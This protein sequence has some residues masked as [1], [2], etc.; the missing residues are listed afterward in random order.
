MHS[1]ENRILM[2]N[3]VYKP[4]KYENEA[5]KFAIYLTLETWQR[6]EITL[7]QLSKYTTLPIDY[8]VKLNL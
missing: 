3:N 7:Q 1:N 8:L 6:K 5:N 4:T 2:D